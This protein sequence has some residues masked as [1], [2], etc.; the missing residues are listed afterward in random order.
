MF[1]QGVAVGLTGLME[2]TFKLS[3]SATR[4]MTWCDSG[5]RETSEKGIIEL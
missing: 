2:G 1:K 3:L 5:S 4:E